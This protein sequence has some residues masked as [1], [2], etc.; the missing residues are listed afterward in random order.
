MYHCKLYLCSEIVSSI[1]SKT[2]YLKIRRDRAS[3]NLKFFYPVRRLHHFDIFKMSQLGK[4][5][6]SHLLGSFPICF[7]ST[8]H[9]L[10]M[11]LLL[12]LPLFLLLSSSLLLCH[13]QT[14]SNS[15]KIFFVLKNLTLLS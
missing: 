12:L 1:S 2:L 6:D 15:L 13:F 3:N 5:F 8:L 11:V 10:I 7:L 9:E 4:S 14:P